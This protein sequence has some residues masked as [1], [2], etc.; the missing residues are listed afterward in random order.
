MIKSLGELRGVLSRS[1]YFSIEVSEEEWFSL[2]AEMDK[3]IKDTWG[4]PLVR[5][6]IKRTHFLA[7]G[8]P[9]FMRND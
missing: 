7:F 5:K 9:I 1:G 8:V 6:G 4:A 2:R 3:L